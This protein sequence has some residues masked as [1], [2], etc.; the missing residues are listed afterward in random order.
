MKLNL[1]VGEK[2]G[3]NYIYT[4]NLEFIKRWMCYIYSSLGPPVLIL[5]IIPKT[6]CQ[7]KKKRKNMLIT[8]SCSLHR[9]VRQVMFLMKYDA[10]PFNSEELL[11]TNKDCTYNSGVVMEGSN[12]FTA[13]IE[14]GQKRLNKIELITT[15]T[16]IIECRSKPTE[17]IWT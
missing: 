9:L 11:Q 14:I 2:E 4:R 15:I 7:N 1:K 3:K 16:I 17:I 10:L 13:W 12:L 8:G 5:L 6:K